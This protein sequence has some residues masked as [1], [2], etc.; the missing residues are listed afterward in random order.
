MSEENATWT[1]ADIEQVK[2]EGN[3]YELSRLL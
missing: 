3:N 1:D 2:K